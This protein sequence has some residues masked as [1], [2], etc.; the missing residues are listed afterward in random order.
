[1][2]TTHLTPAQEYAVRMM[3]AL[4]GVINSPDNA[5]C[6]NDILAIVLERPK[7]L[8]AA[9]AAYLYKSRSAQVSKGIIPVMDLTCC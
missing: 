2:T 6:S 1:M 9:L 4:D 5:T 8:R 7:T 3:N